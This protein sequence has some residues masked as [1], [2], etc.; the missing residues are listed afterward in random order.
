MITTKKQAKIAHNLS[1]IAIAVSLAFA[2]LVLVLY[3]NVLKIQSSPQESYN[4]FAGEHEC[5]NNCG[6]YNSTALHTWS[7]ADNR[8]HCS[9][10]SEGKAV[11]LW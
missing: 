10:E 11:T 8:W 2:M 4:H 6:R 3:A 5:K 9:C 7:Y 1:A